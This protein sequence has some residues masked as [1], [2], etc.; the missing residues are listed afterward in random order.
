[1]EGIGTM[2]INKHPVT[3]KTRRYTCDVEEQLK[4]NQDL[5][6]TMNCLTRLSLEETNLED[7]LRAALDLI[8][9]IPWLSVQSKGSIFIVEDEP[10][11]LVMKAQSGLAAPLLETC[12]RVPFGR[13]LCGRAALERKIQFAAHLDERHETRYEGIVPHGHYCVP[14][15]YADRILGVINLYVR[16]GHVRQNNEEEFLTAIADTL[17]G[18]IIRKRGEEA[19]KRSIAK[20]RRTLDGVVNALAVTAEK[21]DPYTAGHQQRV[22][23]LACAIAKEMRLPA[24]QIDGIRVAATLHDIGKIAVPSEILTKPGQLT[25]LEWGLIRCHP[26]AGYEILKNIPFTWPV[27]RIVLQ[28][29][30]RMNGS[31]YPSGLSGEEILLEARILAIADVVEAMAS[32][33]PYRPALGI[34]EAL[35]E[36]SQNSGV[37][38]DSDAVNACLRLFQKDDL[39]TLAQC[40][41]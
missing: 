2:Y 22:A 35:T 37:L 5:L 19:L 7:I 4:R 15:L 11:V 34:K 40:M 30:E 23:H 10:G 39:T 8:V 20:M 21:R 25:E 3:H 17:A 16:D 6:A 32:H 27:A 29:H 14:I 28:H 24:D 13:C 41:P 36:I 31:G 18:I 38:Y 26:Q 12:A 9:S 1:M 33:R